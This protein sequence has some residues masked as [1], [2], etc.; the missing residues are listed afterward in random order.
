[1]SD[2]QETP[3]IQIVE[4]S[5]KFINKEVLTPE[6]QPMSGL[7]KPMIEQSVGMMAQDLQSFLKG[8]EQV[9]L[10]A[11]SKLA[12]NILTY[13]TYYHN[14]NPSLST[15]A[16]LEE[17]HAVK[18]DSP[19]SP[20]G[21]QAIKELFNIVGEYGKQKAQMNALLSKVH[22]GNL[23]AFDFGDSNQN[24]PSPATP[25]PQHETPVNTS[26]KRKNSGFSKNNSISSWT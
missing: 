16:S 12:S 3:N 8:F 1:M 2:S 26:K 7:A 15:D 19:Y 23:E 18:K 25:A 14:P 20:Q 6:A 4:D 9:G 17:N 21:E 13:G 24:K 22:T 5:V 10:I 11:L